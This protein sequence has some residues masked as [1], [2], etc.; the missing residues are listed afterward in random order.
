MSADPSIDDDNK[1][2][3]EEKEKD[4]NKQKQEEKEKDDLNLPEDLTQTT[5]Q[6]QRQC[7]KNVGL[8]SPNVGDYWY[9]IDKKWYNSWERY[10]MFN[11]GNDDIPGGIENLHKIGEPRPGKI[12]NAA[13][14]DSENPKALKRDIQENRTHIWLH[15]DVWKL[16]CSWY[17]GGPE[18]PRKVF[19]RGN[20][21]NK[22][23]YICIYP[24]LVELIY[25]ND[26]TGEININNDNKKKKDDDKKK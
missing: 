18:F 1:Q 25:C 3:Q 23:K 11:K 17:G 10:T 5:P 26:K 12:D 8:K 14:Q 21:Y 2:K 16:L 19:E 6:Q 22:E 20:R 24:Q 7:M 4:D 9:P 15:Q 13:L